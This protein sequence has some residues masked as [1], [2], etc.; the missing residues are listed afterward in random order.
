MPTA[1]KL[2]AAF[3][4]AI[5]GYLVAESVRPQLPEGQ[6]T[7]W[8]IQVSV[9]IPMICGWRV[10][11]KL[12]GKNYAVAI[13]SGVYGVAVSLF[14]VLV[15]FSVSEMIKLSTRLRYDG[16]VEAII[17][18]FGILFDY[19]LLLIHPNTLGL[20]AGMAVIGGLAAE[21]AHRKFE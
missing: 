11:G 6:S 16:P 4:F 8:L 5:G 20:L 3:I 17:S 1:A 9:F 14:F 18:S 10:L 13:N 7:P 21:W 15:T 12:V 19:G 2:V